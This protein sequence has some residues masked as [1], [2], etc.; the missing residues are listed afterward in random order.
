MVLRD[1][2]S[3]YGAQMS[4]ARPPLQVGWIAGVFLCAAVSLALLPH[5]AQDESYHAFADHRT[6]WSIPNFWNVV[7]NLPFAIVG[8]LGLWR[9][10]GT[11]ARVLSTGLLLTCVGSVNY[12]L[13]PTDTRLI[14]DRLPMTLV[15][16]SFVAAVIAQGRSRRWETLILA[17][18]LILGVAS[19]WWWKTSGDLLPYVLVQFG[20]VMVILPAFWRATGKRWLWRI[21]ALYAAAKIAEL[22]DPSIYSALPWSGHTWK[23]LLGAAAGY[24]IVRWFCDSSQTVIRSSGDNLTSSVVS[25]YN[26]CGSDSAV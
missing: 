3:G 15:F 8:V 21:A 1:S 26:G 4:D 23:H 9:L 25:T 11:T 17:P 2:L 19:I 7:S 10:R 18:L 24:C 13:V 16:M 22:Y 5:V 20:P 6:I 14:W 12:H